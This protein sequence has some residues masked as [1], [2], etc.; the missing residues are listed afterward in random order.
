LNQDTATYERKQIT[1]IKKPLLFQQNT[2]LL[3]LTTAIFI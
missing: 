3:K 2:I 1:D